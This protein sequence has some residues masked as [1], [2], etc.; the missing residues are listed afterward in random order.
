MRPVE[1]PFK[2]AMPIFEEGHYRAVHNYEELKEQIGEGNPEFPI[3]KDVLLQFYSI[4][5][6]PA[7]ERVAKFMIDTLND[8]SLR[9]FQNPHSQSTLR[10]CSLLPHPSH[11]TDGHRQTGPFHKVR[12][13]ACVPYRCRK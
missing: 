6:Q 2:L 13:H 4:T 7:Y 9:G 12:P 10:P 3:D 8:P 1:I 5:D 11:P